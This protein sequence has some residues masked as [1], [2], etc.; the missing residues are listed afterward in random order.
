MEPDRDTEVQ[1]AV[2][3]KKDGRRIT[4]SWVCRVHHGDGGNTPVL[5]TTRGIVIGA[6]SGCDLVVDDAAVSSRHLRLTLSAGGVL[7]EDLGSTNGT[8]LR[9]T[10]IDKVVL[11]SHSQVTI[12]ST[13]VEVA[14]A[15]H[16]D[17]PPH[18][19]DHFGSLV[20]RSVVMRKCFAIMALAAKTDAT[21]VIEGESGTG[22]ELAARAIHENSQRANRPFVVVDCAGIPEQLIESH[23]FGHRQGAFTGAV[24]S[25]KGAFVLADGGSIFLDE[26][27]ELPL[28]AQGKLL[29]V[30]EAQTVQ[31]V[32][33]E[34]PVHVN[35]RVIAATNRNLEQM[36]A[37][38]KFRFDLFH[39]LSV[40]RFQMPALRDHT[41]DIPGL[42]AHFY[43]SRNTASGDIAGEGL[44]RLIHYDWPGN[45]RELRNVLE[46]AWVLSGLA[47]PPFGSLQ[48]A[49][50]HQLNT[51]ST[52]VVDTS[53]PYKEAKEKWLA[54]FE[55]EYVKTVIKESNGNISR[56]AAH[57]GLNRNH[58]RKLMEKCGLIK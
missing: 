45:V 16:I 35:V 13:P 15:G 21:V 31:P 10:R 22:K 39:R 41:D 55:E 20:G 54:V 33:A 58:L 42:I 49:F 8:F 30:L 2:A 48:F 3:E 50:H 28:V 34:R 11:T 38:D 5:I 17:V 40:V 1:H 46:R 26:L 12:G 29:R 56:A 43:R 36:V 51:A 57:A 27:G 18:E 19:A 14:P 52:P 6:S 53:M 25:R 32:G 23:L 37:E 24:E 4:P 9:T 47:A 44:R 7:V